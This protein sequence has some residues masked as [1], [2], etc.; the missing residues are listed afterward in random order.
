MATGENECRNHHQTWS[1]VI[2]NLWPSQETHIFIHTSGKAAVQF[3]TVKMGLIILGKWKIFRK[4]W[5][6]EMFWFSFN[7]VIL[8]FFLFNWPPSTALGHW[9]FLKSLSSS[10]GTNSSFSTLVSVSTISLLGQDIHALESINMKSPFFFLHLV[11]GCC[12]NGGNSK[13]QTSWE[14]E[15]T[16]DFRATASKLKWLPQ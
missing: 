1:I 15:P 3:F 7:R 5:S 8:T 11:S 14:H 6:C 12:R 13:V 2:L 10:S 9:W 4:N 16:S